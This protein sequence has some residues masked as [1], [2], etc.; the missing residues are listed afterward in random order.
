MREPMIVHPAPSMSVI[1]RMKGRSNLVKMTILRRWILISNQAGCPVDKMMI[2]VVHPLVLW[3]VH[4]QCPMEDS[5]MI[6]TWLNLIVH[7]H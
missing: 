7:Q 6:R 2:T 1:G 5:M 4:H 3:M